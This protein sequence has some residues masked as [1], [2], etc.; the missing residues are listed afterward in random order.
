MLAGCLCIRTD[1][2]STFSGSRGLGQGRIVFGTHFFT[3]AKADGQGSG[4]GRLGIFTDGHR[5]SLL[6]IV[7][8]RILA[9]GNGIGRGR[10]AAQPGQGIIAGSRAAFAEGQSILPAGGRIAAE[11][12]GTFSAGFRPFAERRGIGAGSYGTLFDILA[13]GILA[14]DFIAAAPGRGILTRGLVLVAEGRS[15]V[16]AGYR[17]VA[18]SRGILAVSYRI[19]AKGRSV[20]LFGRGP[21]A[22]S[23]S[24][25]F[26]SLSF[27]AESRGIG[28]A[29]RGPF[30][31]GN[32]IL[33]AGHIVR[34]G[35]RGIRLFA[36]ESCCVIPGGAGILA[37]DRGPF[38]F[39][40][41]TGPDG[42]CIFSCSRGADTRCQ[43]VVARRSPGIV[44][45]GIRSAV[46][47]IHAV[48]V[49]IAA[50]GAAAP[51]V[52][53]ERGHLFQ[54]GHVDGI[55]IFFPGGYIGNLAGLLSIVDIFRSIPDIMVRRTY[56][57]SGQS[58]IPHRIGTGIVIFVIACRVISPLIVGFPVCISLA[59]QSHGIVNI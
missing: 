40:C 3:D 23:R 19:L 16:I 44:I 7:C 12:R 2:N 58:R 49:D 43:S 57:N 39:S 35:C 10:R 33:P 51:L 38:A 22:K 8:L 17:Q 31:K 20:G 6:C 29:G 21:L 50:A 59:A 30:P 28:P 11:G 47:R 26:R 34:S 36:P 18:E 13:I 42:H 45:V 41:G 5:N 24:P 46:H 27:Q 52:V 15:A 54:L 56:G 32:C 14:D 4:A 9:Q 1:R 48:I 25:F 55:R 53:D 37:D